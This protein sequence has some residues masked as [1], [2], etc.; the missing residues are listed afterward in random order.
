M[1]KNKKRA[2]KDRKSQKEFAS[3]ENPEEEQLYFDPAEW[4]EGDYSDEKRYWEE[5]FDYEDEHFRQKEKK[6]LKKKG[7]F[8]D[9]DFQ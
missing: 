7:K 4:D 5:Y 2:P 9:R 1:S 8:R 3:Q 6:K